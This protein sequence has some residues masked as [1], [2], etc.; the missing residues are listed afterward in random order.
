MAPRLTLPPVCCGGVLWWSTLNTL[1][2]NVNHVVTCLAQKLF[3][4]PPIPLCFPHIFRLV[5]SFLFLCLKDL[6]N[7]ENKQEAHGMGDVRES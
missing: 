7:G 1:V 6:Q 2:C 3:K 5:S 4:T